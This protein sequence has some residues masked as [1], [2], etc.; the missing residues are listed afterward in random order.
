VLVEQPV[1]PAVEQLVEPPDEL[2]VEL[3]DEPPDGPNTESLRAR[4]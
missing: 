1:D 2:P 3:R 4:L